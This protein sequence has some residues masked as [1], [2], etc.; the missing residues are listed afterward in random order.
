MPV[1]ARSAD[2]RSDAVLV[3]A[4]QQVEGGAVPAL[5]AGDEI[6]VQRF[7]D[8]SSSAIACR[9]SLVSPVASGPCDSDDPNPDGS[10]APCFYLKAI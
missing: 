8:T 10:S 7:F 5:H 9:S 2:Q 1:V 4:H 3:L 6:L